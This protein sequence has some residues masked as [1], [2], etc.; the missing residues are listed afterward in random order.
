MAF[1]RLHLRCTACWARNTAQR[2]LPTA[3]VKATAHSLVVLTVIYLLSVET[4]GC[5]W[6]LTFW[7]KINSLE[8]LSELGTPLKMDSWPSKRIP[9]GGLFHS[10]KVNYSK[11]T[12]DL[13]KRKWTFNFSVGRNSFDPIFPPKCWWKSRKCRFSN[14]TNWS[15]SFGAELLSHF[16]LPVNPS[17]K[18]LKRFLELRGR[19]LPIDA[20]WRPSEPV[21]PSSMNGI[22]IP[23]GTSASDQSSSPKGMFRRTIPENRPTNRRF[24]CKKEWV[25]WNM[26]PSSTSPRGRSSWGTADTRRVIQRKIP[27]TNVSLNALLWFRCGFIRFI[28]RQWCKRF[29]SELI[30][31]TKW[32]S[33]ARGRSI[34]RRSST[35]SLN[36]CESSSN[37]RKAKLSKTSLRKSSTKR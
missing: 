10:R 19:G 34:V 1:Y 12:H 2:A 8:I 27:S 29:V 4:V 25:E 36:V 33:W 37:S 11:E 31:S 13:L 26:S 18:R 28:L 21:E 35:K 6:I 9:Q 16:R 23:F 3:A 15:T 5:V 20:H 24:A 22:C 7:G 14:E 30:G 32:S 17:R